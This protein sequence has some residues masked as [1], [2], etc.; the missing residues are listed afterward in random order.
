MTPA[1]DEHWVPISS[2]E[3]DLCCLVQLHKSALRWH[4]DQVIKTPIVDSLHD[5]FVC[6]VT[7]CVYQVHMSAVT[8]HYDH[9][10]K[11]QSWTVCPVCLIVL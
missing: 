7:C 2:R 10:M 1:F 9:V 3:Y 6:I 11:S 8:C 5:I 4:A